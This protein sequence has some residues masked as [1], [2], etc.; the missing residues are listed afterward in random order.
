MLKKVLV[1]L[2][3]PL[4]C[5]LSLVHFWCF[6]S[7]D[8]GIGFTILYL[9]L[10]YPAAIFGTSFYIARKDILGRKKWLLCVI[11]GILM[12]VSYYCTFPLANN[13]AF[14]KVNFPNIGIMIGG[15][16]LAAIGMI[17]GEP[18]RHGNDQKEGWLP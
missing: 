7:P 16:A 10:A 15:G 18:R 1:L 11:Y 2:I 13:L 17:V 12:M 9:C 4:V 8:G 5:A 3:F 14:H 6:M